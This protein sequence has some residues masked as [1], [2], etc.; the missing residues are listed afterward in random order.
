MRA[1]SLFLICLYPVV[2][3]GQIRAFPY[4]VNFDDS[5]VPALPPGWTTTSS[6]SAAGDFATTGTSPF[7]PPNAVLVTNA[8]D[9]QIFTSPQLDFRDK[10]PDSLFFFER[11]S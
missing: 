7:S 9:G 10:E 1:L 5:T 3:H 2:L 8:T 4:E 6:R 11:R